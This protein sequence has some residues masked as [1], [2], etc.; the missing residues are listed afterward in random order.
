[1]QKI[2]IVKRVA[3][4]TDTTMRVTATIIDAFLYVLKNAVANGE[5]VTMR[6]IGSFERKE[7]KERGGYNFKTGEPTIIPAS[8]KVVFKPSK[9]FKE[10][11]KK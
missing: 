10:A 11:V 2:D 9:E 4:E 8:A 7:T 1:M 6:E 5:S 3:Y